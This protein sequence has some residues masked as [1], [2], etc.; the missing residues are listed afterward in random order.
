MELQASADIVRKERRKKWGRFPKPLF[1]LIASAS[2]HWRDYSFP[3]LCDKAICWTKG[4]VLQ[5]E[6][7]AAHGSPL[8]APRRCYKGI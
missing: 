6:H 1:L 7:P 2:G 3:R 5:S 8:E 4:G